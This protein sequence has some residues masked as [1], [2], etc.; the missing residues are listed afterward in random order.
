MEVGEQSWQYYFI[1]A[2][3]HQI[4]N[5]EEPG[6]L[7]IDLASRLNQPER[8]KQFE[9][10][11]RRKDDFLWSSSLIYFLIRTWE[12][13]EECRGLNSLLQPRTKTSSFLFPFLPREWGAAYLGDHSRA[14]ATKSGSLQAVKRL[15]FAA[16]K[17]KE[18]SLSKKQTRGDK[19]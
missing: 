16:S 14:R 7:N 15:V 2:V 17:P 19:M 9:R 18:G 5:W 3:S 1:S 8:T 12:T 4:R 6:Q 10:S 11:D 13:M